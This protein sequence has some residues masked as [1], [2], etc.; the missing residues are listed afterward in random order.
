MQNY[1]STLGITQTANQECI[2][3]TYRALVKVYHSDLYKGEKKIWAD[4]KLKNLNIAY[5]ILSFVEE[6]VACLS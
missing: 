6:E 3:K 4:E 5:E 2:K 1:Y